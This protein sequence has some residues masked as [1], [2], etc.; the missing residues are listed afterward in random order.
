MENQ[1]Q[2]P[3]SNEEV[4]ITPAPAEGLSE[5]ATKITRITSKKHV[6]I[7]LLYSVALLTKGDVARAL[8]TNAG[9]VGNALKDYEN[10][11]AKK[12]SANAIWAKESAEVG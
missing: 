4:Q 5:V 11:P 8:G 9:H 12:E 1:D 10:N 7:W 3:V 2:E 6:K